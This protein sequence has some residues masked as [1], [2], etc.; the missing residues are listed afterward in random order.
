[1]YDIFDIVFFSSVIICLF[2][3]SLYFIYKM[4]KTKN[5]DS[6]YKIMST[7][8]F[9]CG[10]IFI[11][12]FW[13]LF[14]LDSSGSAK[15][16]VNH[17]ESILVNINKKYNKRNPTVGEMFIHNMVYARI[18]DGQK[19]SLTNANWDDNKNAVINI[20]STEQFISFD[21]T[22]KRD[23]WNKRAAYLYCINLPL[24]IN[25]KINHS[26]VY[27][28]GTLIKENKLNVDY[29]KDFCL[30]QKDHEYKIVFK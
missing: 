5:N 30:G 23:L 3:F 1:M 12:P 27:V 28:D 15:R 16:E 24:Y 4:K 9:I 17:L 13:N 19:V 21:Y 18:K 14:N 29:M 6:F 7:A 8:S 20:T 2:T 10:L 22:I 26:E 11:I 25:Q